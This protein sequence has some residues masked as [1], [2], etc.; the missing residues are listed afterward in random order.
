MIELLAIR[1]GHAYQ[2]A[3]LH[4][5]ARFPADDDVEATAARKSWFGAILEGFTFVPRIWWWAYRRG[6]DKRL[7][8]I[9][10]GV[11][12]PVTAGRGGGDLLH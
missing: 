3:H 2:M 4:H 8:V 1:S 5:H 6:G 11:D 12:V 9:G 10:E 7:W